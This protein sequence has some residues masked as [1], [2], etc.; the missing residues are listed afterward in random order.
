MTGNLLLVPTQSGVLSGYDAVSGK[1]LWRYVLQA[2]ATDS[3]PKAPSTEVYAAPIVADG[4]LYVVSDD[5]TLSAFRPDAPDNVGPQL[6]QLVPDAGATVPSA[7]LFYGALLEMTAPASIRPQSA[8]QVDGNTDAQAQYHAGQNAI[9]NAPTALLKE[10]THQI[11][12]KATDWRGNA[13][14]QSWTFLVN[15]HP[16]IPD[17][18]GPISRTARLQSEQPELSRHRRR[19]SQRTP[20]AATHRPF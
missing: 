3:Q 1:L 13:T 14:T 4:A 5:G 7:N 20:A 17:A 19:Q 18:A 16:D 11:T 12:V 9:Y 15:D 6:T 10:G 8:C 2:S